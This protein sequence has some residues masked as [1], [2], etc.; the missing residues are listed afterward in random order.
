MG[1]TA[2]STVNYD[3]YLDTGASGVKQAYNY[4]NR[5]F[6]GNGQGLLE[7]LK[8]NVKLMGSSIWQIAFKPYTGTVSSDMFSRCTNLALGARLPGA[9]R[10]T[11]AILGAGLGTA[12]V[13]F[14]A[15]QYFSSWQVVKNLHPE[16][17]KHGAVLDFSTGTLAIGAG[18]G[19]LV[20]IV[21]PAIGIA[22][23]KTALLQKMVPLM[24]IAALGAVGIRT[25]SEVAHDE[26]H[27]INKYSFF[28]I[29]SP[30]QDK[31][32]G[33]L[34]ALHPIIH[35]LTYGLD[36]LILGPLGFEREATTLQES[37]ERSAEIIQKETAKQAKK[38][39]T[40]V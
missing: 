35:W 29:F 28:G 40:K 20:S 39:D 1:T 7:N 11:G 27:W 3:R 23:A 26:N 21:N 34:S 25:L 10:F 12:A 6:N 4:I 30:L 22:G 2:L 9:L 24:S 31:V 32:N 16:I 15:S 33:G 37:E 18:A 17:R 13:C 19:A 38:L 8:H 36:K 5:T 14:G